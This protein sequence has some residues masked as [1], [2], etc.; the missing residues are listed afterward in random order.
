[1]DP[2]LEKMMLLTSRL[3]TNS[4]PPPNEELVTAFREFF[5][6]QSNHRPQDFQIQHAM[7]TWKYLQSQY[8]D[9]TITQVLQEY[10]LIVALERIKATASQSPVFMQF[11]TAI[12]EFL[13]HGGPA[14][15]A[16]KDKAVDGLCLYLDVICQSRATLQGRDLL[17]EWAPIMGAKHLRRAWKS[18][19]KGFERE[20]NESE[21]LQSCKT[22]D[23]LF[24]QS[25]YRARIWTIVLTHYL[26]KGNIAKAKELHSW[27]CQKF[28]EESAI[29][30]I[31]VLRH[32]IQSGERK[33]SEE[34]IAPLKPELG[35]TLLWE[36]VLNWSAS[37]GK[38]VEE[39]N[40]M[41]QVLVR[42][43]ADTSRPFQPRTTTI[44]KLVE[45]AGSRNDPYTAER[46]MS[47]GKQW[48]LTPD[49]RSYILQ[50]QYRLQSGDIS[51][52]KNAY[53]ALQSQEIQDD[54]DIPI[55]NKY[56]QKLCEAHERN[57]EEIDI[58]CQDLSRRRV[59]FEADT[60]KALC[61][62][63]LARDEL[64]DLIDLLNM[65]TFGFSSSERDTISEILVNYCLDSTNGDANVWDIYVVLH[66]IFE[67]IPRDVR[68]RIMEAFF[69][70]GRPDM[71]VHAFNHMRH[72][73]NSAIRAVED[74]YAAAFKGI[75]ANGDVESA[76]LVHNQMK[77][78]PYMEPNTK[79]LN[80]L[81][82]AQISCDRPK[83]A[84]EIWKTIGEST[85]GPS[86]NSICI[87]LRACEK[88][89]FGVE[90]ARE[91]W[92][93]LEEMD[94]EI[95]R[96]IFAAWIGALSSGGHVDEAIE[97]CLNAPQK[98]GIRVDE[99]M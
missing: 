83:R 17:L 19:I 45:M 74:T 7:N 5:L 16:D 82:L 88:W 91:I 64:H 55:I 46:L 29:A 50:I 79:V 14:G 25:S 33:W 38:G 24:S 99:L 72:H 78:D 44:N 30:T 28:P 15:V 70:R 89:P 92:A 1:M 8:P 10:V 87:A 31:Q 71:G 4:R 22:A 85:E 47:L 67:D 49:A 52:A 43:T 27:I 93:L 81:M 86:Y 76:D 98:Y 60:V 90:R 68:T 58:A 54:E 40:H 61:K 97:A 53:I 12:W 36:E 26:N 57:S 41:M 32:C 34:I 6:S 13:S 42:R 96:D 94:V 77:V 21:L 69:H 51:G 2:G 59:C 75:A 3:Q 66:K 80:A 63:H 65:H 62:M 18:I 11:A 9:H 95:D 48:Q 23:E 56:I 20:G 39:I 84:L 37:M 73:P 35:N